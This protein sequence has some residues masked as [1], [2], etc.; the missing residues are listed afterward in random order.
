MVE[1]LSSLLHLHPCFLEA[2]SAT[3]VSCLL[4]ET[5]YIHIHVYVYTTHNTDTH[6]YTSPHVESF[7]FLTHH[8]VPCFFM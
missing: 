5:S 4:P 8:S 6:A 7:P 3:S 2:S 1:S